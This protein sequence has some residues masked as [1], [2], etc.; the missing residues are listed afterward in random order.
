MSWGTGLQITE[1][2]VTTFGTLLAIES[3]WRLR[4]QRTMKFIEDTSN[5]FG[6]KVVATI[7]LGAIF[8]KIVE[9]LKKEMGIQYYKKVQMTR[10]KRLEIIISL[11]VLQFSNYVEDVLKKI[12]KHLIGIG[13]SLIIVGASMQIFGVLI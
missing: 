4:I 10:K 5:K 3:L 8:V 7:I 12:N 1:I 13:V 11:L 9:E 2:I 6:I